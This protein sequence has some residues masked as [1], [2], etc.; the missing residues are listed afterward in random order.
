MIVSSVSFFGTQQLPLKETSENERDAFEWWRFSFSLFLKRVFFYYKQNNNKKILF[1]MSK[2]ILKVKF[3]C[4]QLQ[5]NYQRNCNRMLF[6]FC[7][8]FVCNYHHT[9]TLTNTILLLQMLLGFHNANNFY[10]GKKLET[11]DYHIRKALFL[12]RFVVYCKMYYRCFEDWIRVIANLTKR[13]KIIVQWQASF[14]K[15]VNILV[16][17]DRWEYGK[18]GNK[19]LNLAE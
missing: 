11:I 3:E 14:S 17:F 15:P 19:K 2:M 1:Q 16:Q 4:S 8:P 6:F 13:L 9:L 7:F 12:Y 5:S 18:K 10:R